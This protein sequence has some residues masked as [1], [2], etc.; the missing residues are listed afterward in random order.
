MKVVIAALLFVAACMPGHAQSALAKSDIAINVGL[1]IPAYLDG[2]RLPL[3]TS[4]FEIGILDGLLNDKASIG[5][6][7]SLGI[8]SNRETYYTLFQTHKDYTHVIVGARGAFHYSPLYRLDTYAGTMIG[9]DFVSPP[10]TTYYSSSDD[11]D[12][13]VAAHF[14]VGIRY[15]LMSNIAIYAEAGYS[16]IAPVEAGIAFRF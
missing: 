15:Y 7:G 5:V 13:R 3:F 2:M 16:V 6:G 14:F 4:S 12:S 11:F 10:R 8:T 1:G 9:Y